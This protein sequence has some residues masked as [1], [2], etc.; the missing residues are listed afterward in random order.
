MLTVNQIS[1]FGGSRDLTGYTADQV[2]T[3][4]SATA[5]S[6]TVTTNDEAN[7]AA[8][9]VFSDAN[10]D[11]SAWNTAVVAANPTS[12]WVAYEFAAAKTIERYTIKVSASYAARGPKS[13]KF[14][15]WDGG[16]YID[17]DSQ[18]AV[19]AWSAAERRT[20]TFANP[21]GYTKY[22]LEVTEVQSTGTTLVIEE[23]EMMEG[24]YS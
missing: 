5:P 22:R 4:T 7:G 14:Q 21:G 15:G 12:K 10:E 20:Y 13:W 23:I 16:A 11:G 24:V 9:R 17:L 18:D 6:G 1:G 2:P 8:W 19:A 3:M